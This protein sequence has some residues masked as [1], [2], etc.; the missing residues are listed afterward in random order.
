MLGE[1]PDP[2]GEGLLSDDV[3][4]RCIIC[5]PTL[6]EKKIFIGAQ[7]HPRTTKSR[8]EVLIFCRSIGN[9]IFFLSS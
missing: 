5:R 9:P 1:D 2:F 7:K 8:Q 3:F 4:V 6:Q